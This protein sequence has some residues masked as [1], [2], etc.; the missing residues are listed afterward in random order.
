MLLTDVQKGLQ[1]NFPHIPPLIFKRTL[2]K[3][4][5]DGEAFD[6]LDTFPQLYPV[7]WCDEQRR[8]ITVDLLEVE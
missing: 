7:A 6:I 1:E 2:E 4:K 5:S 3:A 8:W